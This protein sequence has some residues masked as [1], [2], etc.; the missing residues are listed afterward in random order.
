MMPL[1]K[2]LHPD[3]N[4]MQKYLR[5]IDVTRIYTNRGY[6]VKEYEERLGEMF[7]CHAA[8]VSSCTS[9]MTACL[10]TMDGVCKEYMIRIPSWAFVAT[11]NAVRMANRNLY[12]VDLGI[13]PHVAVSEFG[14]APRHPGRLL[15]D[16]A[17]AFG[18][19][20]SGYAKVGAAPV[21]ISTHAT[22]VFS[23]GEGGIVLSTDEGF[24]Q[25]IRTTI[26]H[27]IDVDRQV[28]AR[29]FNGKMSEF[30]AAAG[31]ASLDAW[32]ETRARWMDAETRYARILGR[33]PRP[34][35][36]SLLPDVL[37]DRFAG[38]VMAK[39]NESG[40][41][42]KAVWGRGVHT[43]AAY[44]DCPRDL[45]PLTENIADRTLFLPFWIDMS[46][47]EMNFVADKF[48]EALRCA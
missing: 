38:P 34:D 43:L 25:G 24:I 39:L 33:V 35:P 4:A 18:V 31:L 42:S 46:D 16:A 10:M 3:R 44:K 30:H 27:G 6:L 1:Q 2:P 17:G 7:H 36:R 13:S 45:M 5:R 22:K 21:V 48:G 15:T 19:Y 26:N 11:A 12:F 23:T 9:G 14:A 47:S 8:A 32:S 40:I 20:A 29:G 28:R 41:G 37:L